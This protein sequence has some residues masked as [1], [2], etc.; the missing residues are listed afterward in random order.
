M[1][2]KNLITA[3]IAV[4]AVG[5]SVEPVMAQATPSY[6]AQD[7]QIHGRV[8]SF[9]GAYTLQVR[10]D[11][12]YVD[13]VQLHQGTIINPIGITLATGMVVAVDGY[14]AG[15]YFAAN[16][17]DTPYT[18]YSGV[19]YFMGYP[20]YHYGPTASLSLFFGQPG[21]WHGAYPGAPAIVNRGVYVHNNAPP[22][23]GGAWHGHNYVASPQHG[24]YAAHN[25]IARAAAPRAPIAR[26][27]VPRGGFAH[28]PAP[29]VPAAGAHGGG[30]PH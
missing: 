8:I 17:V 13:N 22:Y 2:I 4:S 18:F 9:D 25:P 28:A 11:H 7:Q 14:N 6:T 20:W 16:E 21:W 10:D 19:P 1:N 26:A 29:H 12:G 15:S 27:P 5:A 23:R 24:G 30:R 3:L